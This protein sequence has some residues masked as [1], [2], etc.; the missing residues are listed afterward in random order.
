MFFNPST[1]SIKSVSK[2]ISFSKNSKG[3]FNPRS[4]FTLFKLVVSILDSLLLIFT[5][6]SLLFSNLISFIKFA[7][8]DFI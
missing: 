1:V 2:F 4:F 5:S 7:C 3:V 6:I 8:I